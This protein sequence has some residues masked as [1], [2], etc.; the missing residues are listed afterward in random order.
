MKYPVLVAVLFHLFRLFIAG[1]TWPQSNKT[2]QLCFASILHCWCAYCLLAQSISLTGKKV[3]SFVVIERASGEKQL[4]LGMNS[5]FESCV[6]KSAQPSTSTLFIGRTMYN[7][8]LYEQTTGNR[9]NVTYYDYTTQGTIA[10]ENYGGCAP[11]VFCEISGSSQSHGKRCNAWGLVHA[12]LI[13]CESLV[14]NSSY[15]H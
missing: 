9:W 15:I 7:V 2:L 4:V 3:D 6:R 14:S 12:T 1:M 8:M 10:D 13:E 11:A 5:I